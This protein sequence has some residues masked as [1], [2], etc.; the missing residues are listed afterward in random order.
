M[1]VNEAGALLLK[2]AG[3]DAANAF[4]LFLV[5]FALHADDDAAVS[6]GV[7]E[8]TDGGHDFWAPAGEADEAGLNGRR[9]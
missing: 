1:I 9:C 7:R 4:A 5:S 2:S 3:V 6:E 8:S